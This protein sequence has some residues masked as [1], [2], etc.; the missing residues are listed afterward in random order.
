MGLS[1]KSIK[2]TK[3][4]DGKAGENDTLSP[5][6]KLA[7]PIKYIV[8]VISLI[9]TFSFTIWV[10]LNDVKLWKEKKDIFFHNGTPI[11]SEYDSFYFARIAKDMVDGKFRIGEP[12]K[13][14]F[15][16]DGILKTKLKDEKLYPEYTISG[17]GPSLIVY[18]IHKITGLSFE[19]ITWYIVYILTS[20]TIIPIFFYGYK[21]DS[22]TAGIIGALI[23]TNSPLFL[24]RTNLMRLDHDM[25]NL[26]FPFTL[27]LFSFLF[28]FER[29][30]RRLLYAVLCSI[31]A[32]MY[33][34]WYGH[35]NIILVQISAIIIADLIV[36]RKITKKE[37]T[38]Y[39]III[40]PQLWYLY[41]GPMSLYSQVMTL[42]F[43]I[44][45]KTSSEKLFSEFP[46]IFM[47]ISELQKLSP[48]EVLENLFTNPYFSVVG[49]IGF[50]VFIFQ[51]WRESI[52]LL[53]IFAIGI[54]SFK[55]GARFT[56]YLAPFAGF[57]FGYLLDTLVRYITK[58]ESKQDILKAFLSF[59]TLIL[60]VMVQT[61]ITN[62]VSTPKAYSTLVADM[63]WIK[64]NTPAQSAIWTWWDY[65]Y[66]FNLYSE[67]ANVHDGGSQS[68]P[69]TYF[70]ARSFAVSDPEKGWLISSFITNYGLKRV[71]DL[72]QSGV[73][74]KDI[75]EKVE[76]GNF[77]K[78]IGTP[79]YW[80]F[81]G[82]LIDKFG[83]INYFGT[84]NF[85]TKDGTPGKII[86]PRKCYPIEKGKIFCED[87]GVEIDLAKRVINV[88]S[89]TIPIR[90]LIVKIGDIINEDFINDKGIDIE[91]T[92][93]KDGSRTLFL[94]LDPQQTESLF[95]RMFILRKYD[96]RFFEL[97][98]DD[99]PVMVVYRVKE[100][101]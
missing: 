43:G 101:Y 97:V 35:S 37:L 22:P 57:G 40:V 31:T 91:I 53:P 24:A 1:G 3:K 23:A 82:D 2:Q 85:K 67:R 46:N 16:P 63:K 89:G 90:K 74:A 51:R 65:G 5:I 39:A 50:V 66:A 98:L 49:L 62:I 25:L 72:L 15:Y 56:M 78:P 99:F 54:L 8:I 7:K 45:S 26:F 47:S 9:I 71:I 59:S 70:V 10:R 33:Y 52:F 93:T 64:D 30:K 4:D 88:A 20:L 12:D 17:N 11:Y 14:R 60:S 27:A 79:L 21:N 34:I 76:K 100:N 55:S 48:K 80:V 36:R 96:R 18:A 83:W 19:R 87:I 41:E 61:S 75:V 28:T 94:I 95:N 32:I 86:L 81:T 84:Y 42:V 6:V 69:K 13:M 29:D 92:D 77:K 73:K 58:D 68:T 44:A 38:E